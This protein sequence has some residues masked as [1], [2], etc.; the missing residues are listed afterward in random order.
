MRALT[1]STK[2]HSSAASRL[3]ERLPLLIANAESMME[4]SSVRE[5]GHTWPLLGV[6]GRNQLRSTLTALP[7]S[8]SGR[9]QGHKQRL[10][11]LAALAANL[12][13]LL[14]EG[15]GLGVVEEL[16]ERVAVGVHTIGHRF[17]GHAAQR[18]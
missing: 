10:E 11:L 6:V 15:H 16:V 9:P 17:Q 7:S 2:V 4:G 8:L 13:M 14:D 12:H 5:S 1:P 3:R 18:G